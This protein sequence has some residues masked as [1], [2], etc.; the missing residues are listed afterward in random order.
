MIYLDYAAHTPV[1]KRVLETYQQASLDYI[2]NPNSVH[3]CGRAA[4]EYFDECTNKIAKL[5]Q[6]EEDEVIYTSGATESNN[7]AIKGIAEAYKHRS[8]RMITTY[9]EHSSITGPMAQLKNQGYEIDMVDLDHNGMVDLEHLEELL[10]EEAVLVSIGYV[11]SELGLIQPIEKI[12]KLLKKY[13]NTVFHVDGTQALGKIPISLEDIDL[14]TCS[15]HKF[16]GIVGSGILI[17]KRGIQLQPLFHGGISTTSDRSGTPDLPSTAATSKALE[18]ALADM[19]ERYEY[20][21]SLYEKLRKEMKEIPDIVENTGSH[22]SPFIFNFSL[23]N[24]KIAEVL[25]AMDQEGI[26]ISSKSACCAVNAPSR[27]VF[28]LTGNRKRSMSSL[29]IGLS[30]LVTE[31]EIEIFIQTLKKILK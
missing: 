26:C 20:V 7:L 18:L 21:S 22:H 27:P 10:E 8:K 28:A 9:L 24:K 12:G 31:E 11:D 3:F 29:R 30:H 23:K 16:Y 4:K 14:F 13:P 25:E 17:K 6:I 2:G 5:L 15:S 19:E 1:D